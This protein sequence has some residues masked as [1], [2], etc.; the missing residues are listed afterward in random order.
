MDTL[1]ITLP[2]CHQPASLAHQLHLLEASSL[3]GALPSP[4]DARV[5]DSNAP[6]RITF[7]PR[8]DL[9]EQ[10]QLQMRRP[11]GPY[12]LQPYEPAPELAR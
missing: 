11:S 3:G 4:V 6:R 10:L 9:E 8:T 7:P 12:C 5:V 1:P 2:G